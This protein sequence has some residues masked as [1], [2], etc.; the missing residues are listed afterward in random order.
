MHTK[1]GAITVNNLSVVC[2]TMV[3]NTKFRPKLMMSFLQTFMPVSI[4]M[5]NLDEN[6]ETGI[7]SQ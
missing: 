6:R 3:G 1:L 7:L 5:S 4:S 2:I